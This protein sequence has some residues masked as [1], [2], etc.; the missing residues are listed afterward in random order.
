VLLIWAAIVLVVA[1]IVAYRLIL[2]SQG[3]PPPDSAAIVPFVSGYMVL[4]A[5]LLG[6]SLASHPR[7]VAARPAML[8]AAAAGLML[9]GVFA[10]FSIGLPIFIA[11]V[12]AAVAAVTIIAGG[13]SR[14]AMLSEVGA[15]VIAVLVL[16]GGFEI[17]QRIIIC[18]PTGTMG[19]G[20]S[21]FLTGAYHYRCANGTLTTYSGDCNGVTVGVDANGNPISANGC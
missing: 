3:G 16:V 1:A 18:P 19:G 6:L 8:A 7:L 21:G 2:N 14:T 4:M 17:T 13:N 10:L 9:L 20:G 15:A 11:G 12:L 5:A